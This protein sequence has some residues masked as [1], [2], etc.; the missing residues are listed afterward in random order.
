MSHDPL[1]A[2]PAVAAPAVQADHAV[3]AEPPPAPTQEQVRAADAV[4]TARSEEEQQVAA[5][6][7]LYGGTLVAHDL[8]RETFGRSEEEDEEQPRQAEPR[9][10]DEPRP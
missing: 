3:P 7:G 8:L 9:L 4:F 5:L 10:P 6:L 1:I 2:A